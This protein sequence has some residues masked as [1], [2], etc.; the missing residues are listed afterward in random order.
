VVVVHEELI[1]CLQTSTKY[2]L[3]EVYEAILD[4]FDTPCDSIVCLFA[5]TK[6]EFGEIE[7]SMINFSNGAEN[8]I[9]D[10]WLSENWTCMKL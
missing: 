7:K 3:F 9:S 5:D 1:S 10:I 4:G 2:A 8:S 6:C